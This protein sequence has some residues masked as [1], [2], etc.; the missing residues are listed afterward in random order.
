MGIF[1]AGSA[2]DTLQ[3]GSGVSGG[4]DR[5]SNSV[6]WQRPKGLVSALLLVVVLGTLGVKFFGPE[7]LENIPLRLNLEHRDAKGNPIN[8]STQSVNRYSSVLEELTRIPQVQLPPTG[9]RFTLQIASE[10]GKKV[11]SFENL[12]A[13]QL[14]PI[15]P[16]TTNG[17]G[18]DDFDK[19]NLM[20]GE[21][22]R[23]GLA[24]AYQE[25][26]TTLA[27]FNDLPARFL[28]TGGEE[29]YS[30]A[31]NGAI[32]P[33]KLARP[34][35]FS[36]INNCLKAGL[37]ELSAIDAVGE[38]YHSWFN[39]PKPVYAEL[40]RRANNI[41][42]S[43]SEILS[44][45]KYKGD[46]TGVIANLGRLRVDGPMVFQGKA[47]VIASKQIG[48]YSTQ[49]SRQKSQNKYYEVTRGYQLFGGHNVVAAKTFADLQ[50]GDIFSTRKFVNPGIYSGDEK[51]TIPFDP[52]W[53]DVEI[54]SVK[55]LTAY[56]GGKTADATEEFFE[57]SVFAKDRQRRIVMGNIPLSLL[58][59]Q[60][61]YL[62]P[63][64]G[65]G[66]NPPWEFAERRHLRLKDGPVPHYAYQLVERGGQWRLENNHEGGIEQLALRVVNRGERTFLRIT[67]VAYERILDLLELEVEVKGPVAQKLR[68]SSSKYKPPL[69]RVYEDVNLI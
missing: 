18:L 50:V 44:A 2:A 62:V 9:S 35:R 14:V 56:R 13:Y 4:I 1:N 30:I 67:F 25:K 47:Q 48:S 42:L 37:W 28:T 3:Y 63:S 8:P 23:N 65:V 69:F 20:L 10:D 36:V 53:E 16:Y 27:Y 52:F 45:L 58:V 43:D 21:F 6:F 22:G 34:K 55:P 12:D 51:K 38:M 24:L 17:A 40:I 11:L 41:Q 19:A 64:F 29:D 15:L 33:N 61:D 31:A 66:V 5:L 7:P 54:K 59:D 49:E 26:N 60:E 46:I 39:M 57:I 32:A 68:A